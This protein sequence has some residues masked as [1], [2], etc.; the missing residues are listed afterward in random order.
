MQTR[1][2]KLENTT[3]DVSIIGGSIAG[4]LA[5]R[6]LAL[7]GFDVTIYEEHREIGVPEK[8]DGLVSA[9]GIDSLGL[10]PPSYIVQNILSKA[11]F[12]SPPPTINRFL[13]L[14]NDF[15]FTK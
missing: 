12:F 6:E 14:K 3:N 11:V 2:S 5:G 8:C 15:C 7:E 4:L 9:S 13:S 10:V 1:N